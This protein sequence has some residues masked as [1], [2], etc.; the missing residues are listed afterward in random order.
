MTPEAA[1][2]IDHINRELADRLRDARAEV[3]GHGLDGLNSYYV[4]LKLALD[5]KEQMKALCKIA[6]QATQLTKLAESLILTGGV[7][8]D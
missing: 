2:T 5:E 7:T 1:K 4:S 6:R 8:D 3:I